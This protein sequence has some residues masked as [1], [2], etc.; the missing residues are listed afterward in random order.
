MELWALRS[1]MISLGFLLMKGKR[2][3]FAVIVQGQTIRLNNRAIYG[4]TNFPF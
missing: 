3:S 2:L 1:Q 4:K